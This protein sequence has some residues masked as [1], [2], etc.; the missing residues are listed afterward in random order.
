MYCSDIETKINKNKQNGGFFEKCEHSDISVIACD[1]KNVKNMAEMFNGCE[2]LKNLD[3]T[4]IDT[5]NVT[6]MPF[7]FYDC[8]QIKNLDISN[9]NVKN[10]NNIF[11]MFGNCIKLETLKFKHFDDLAIGTECNN[12]FY[13]CK[14]LTKIEMDNFYMLRHFAEEKDT[15]IFNYCTALSEE[16]N[17]KKEQ[18]KNKKEQNIENKEQN[19]NIKNRR[20]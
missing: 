12:L 18:N 13:G 17:N 10:V 16:L 14:M 6:N 7:M 5:S 15:K 4:K 20:R 9:F 2:N 19:K 11:S 8:K 3:I 1:T